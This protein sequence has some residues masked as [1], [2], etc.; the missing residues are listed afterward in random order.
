MANDAALVFSDRLCR[1]LNIANVPVGGLPVDEAENKVAQSLE[2]RKLKPMLSLQ[3]GD[4]NWDISWDAIADKPEATRLVRRAFGVGRTGN[5]LERMHSQYVTA[6]GGKTISLGLTPDMVKLRQVVEMIAS[7]LD[8]DPVDATLIETPAGMR[9]GADVTGIRVDIAATLLQAAQAI[10]SGTPNVVPIVATEIKATIRASDLQGIDGL[11]ASFATTYD[12]DD[13]NRARNIKLAMNGLNGTLIKSGETYS[14]NDRVGLRSPERGYLKAPTL[15]NK[16]IVM[17]WGGG[18]CQVSST[19]YNA[20]LLS[21][22]KIVERSPHYQPP[23]YVPI[24][25]D[26]TVADG[27][28]DLKFQNLSPNPAY[29]KSVL[30]SGKLEVRI[31]GKRE[32]EDSL[33]RIEATEKSVRGQQTLIVQDSS[34]SL[35]KEIVDSEGS[36]GFIVTVQRIRLKGKQ[37]ISRETISTDEFDG[38]D[39]I[40]RVGTFIEDETGRK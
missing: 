29:I 13:E 1:G 24:G 23:G 9:I 3:F 10:T 6:N 35:G 4:K 32:S 2:Q 36:P 20:A 15:T 19:L 37:E 14:F 17:D 21:G 26:A 22:F 27:Q 8:R 30:S 34:L 18:V 40:V 39:R 11:L 12:S 33:I 38:Q 7:S 5:L 31:Y 16:G 25:L 28:I